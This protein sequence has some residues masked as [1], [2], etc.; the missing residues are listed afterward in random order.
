MVDG[1]TTVY[2]FTLQDDKSIYQM[3]PSLSYEI[4]LTKPGD[5]VSISYVDD[6][7]DNISVTDFDNLNIDTQKSEEQEKAEERANE[8]ET[9]EAKRFE[10]DQK[11]NEEIWDSLTPEEK[12]KLLDEIKN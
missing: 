11:K 1:T 5:Q 9:D 7:N 10:L 3:S 6:K 12:A 2:M 8:A 4:V